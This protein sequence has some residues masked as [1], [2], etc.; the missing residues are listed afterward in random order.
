MYSFAQRSDTTVED[1]P[2]YA[3]YLTKTEVDHPGKLDVLNAQSSNEEEVRQ[4]IFRDRPKP[5]VFIKNMAHHIE[6]LEDDLFLNK[7]IN[8]FLIRDPKQI[9]ASYA[10]VI[11]SPMLRDIGIEYE[12]QLFNKL[13]EQNPIVI[14]SGLLLQNPQS[15]LQKVCE[16]ASTPF[17]ENMLRWQAGPK[18]YDGV[19]A[20]YWYANVHQSTGFEKQSTSERSFP[21]QFKP[22]LDEANKYYQELIQHAIKP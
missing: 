12:Y 2:F 11:D 8:I 22:L 3:C 4:A 17:E 21:D 16:R 19:W 6:I 15:V 10:Q 7:C 9:I 14:D 20:P 1:E 5:V 18:P 13:K